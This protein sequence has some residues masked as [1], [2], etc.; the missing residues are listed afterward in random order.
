MLIFSGVNLRSIQ[1]TGENDEL[2]ENI[3]SEEV[4][5]IK[6]IPESS[7]YT[8]RDPIEIDGSAT[9]VDA[10]NWTWAKSQGMCSGYGNST[11]LYIIENY[12]IT[13]WDFQK[14]CINITNSI[15]YFEIRN[16]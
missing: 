3:I 7:A 9:G 8:V 1:L 6:S 11:P 15:A 5:E 13:G 10:N 12:D 2:T 16:Y 14:C 4:V